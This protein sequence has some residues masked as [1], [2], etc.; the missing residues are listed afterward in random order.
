MIIISFVPGRVRPSILQQ[1]S[2]RTVTQG[3]DVMLECIAVGHPAPYIRWSRHGEEL[4]DGW[5]GVSISRLGS[6]MLSNVLYQQRGEY[7]CTANNSLG[8]DSVVM[9]LNVNGRQHHESV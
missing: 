9:P 4:K 5:D 3:E 7:M 6:L 8:T 1:P 2:S